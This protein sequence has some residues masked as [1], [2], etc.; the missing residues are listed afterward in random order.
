MK[1]NKKVSVLIPVYNQE[2]LVVR[3]LDSVPRREDVEV[4]VFNDGSIDSTYKVLKKYKLE[5]P[6]LNLKIYSN[7]ENHGC[8]YAN[9]RLLERSKGEYFSILGSDDYLY[10]DEYNKIIDS[11]LDG[12]DVVCFNLRTNNGTIFNL[13]ENTKEGLCGQSMRLTRKEFIEGIT[14]PEN[15]KAASDWF[16]N[17]ECLARNPKIKYT[18]VVAYHYN[19]PR[20]GS[21]YDQL[22]KGQI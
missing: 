9:N 10:T 13:N 20:N 7:S 19:Y 5:H 18:G 12:S 22:V 16:F 1:I 17:Q 11:E 15:K 21:L 2:E 14:F 4:L 6:E 8:A 3:A